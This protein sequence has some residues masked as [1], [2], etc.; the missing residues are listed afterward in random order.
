[1]IYSQEIQ[2]L[3]NFLF[4]SSNISDFRKCHTLII[5]DHTLRLIPCSDVRKDDITIFRLMPTELQEGM[6]RSRFTTM[7]D[8]YIKIKKQMNLNDHGRKN[9]PTPK[10]T[11]D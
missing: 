10:N 1:M 8:K 6:T 7:A 4:R 5:R 11:D 9:G 2:F 3:S